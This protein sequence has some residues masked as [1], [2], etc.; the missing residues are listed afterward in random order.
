MAPPCW[1]VKLRFAGLTVMFDVPPL[2]IVR[3]T[4]TV[5]AGALCDETVIVNCENVP[6]DK[7]E[8]S[9]ETLVVPGVVPEVGL[10]LK[11]GVLALIFHWSWV[12]VLPMPKVWLGG[13]G[14]PCVAVKDRLVG[15]TVSCVAACVKFKVAVT[16]ALLPLLAVTVIVAV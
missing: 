2:V 9:I 12:P 7:P 1:A 14:P 11:R 3:P 4:C 16:V 6:A 15:L 10:K 8:L 5:T 13:L